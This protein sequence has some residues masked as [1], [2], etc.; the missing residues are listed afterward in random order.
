[1][2]T[3]AFAP[4]TLFESLQRDKAFQQEEPESALRI[5]RLL[6]DEV[7][8]AIPHELLH[9]PVT[10]QNYLELKLVVLKLVKQQDWVTKLFECY[11]IAFLGETTYNTAREQQM[12]QVGELIEGYQDML[13]MIGQ[14]IPKRTTDFYRTMICGNLS[15][16][17]VARLENRSMTL[18]E[19]FTLEPYAVLRFDQRS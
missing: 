9:R 16:P 12:R 3:L 15:E 11:P 6:C 17:T 13:M 5:W 19:L 10:P 1:M 14:W 8:T 4:H 2:N 18:G 7:S